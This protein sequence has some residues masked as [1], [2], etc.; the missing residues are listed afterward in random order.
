MDYLEDEGRLYEFSVL[1][2]AQSDEYAIECFDMAAD[3]RGLIGVLRVDP[4]GAAY[5]TLRTDVTVRLLRRWLEVAEAEA[6]LRPGG[7]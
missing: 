6:G 5:L 7:T 3:G 4:V 2:E 1:S